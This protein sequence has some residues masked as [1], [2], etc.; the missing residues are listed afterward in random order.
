MPEI[1]EATISHLGMVQNVVSRMA[2]NSLVLKALAVTLM[3]GVL[4]FTGASQ[5][6]SPVLALAALV[7]VLA[8]WFLDAHYL[9]LERLFR[10]LYDAVRRG[11]VTESF[12]MNF[13][14]FEAGEQP[15]LRIAFSWSVGWFYG[16]LLIVLIVLFLALTT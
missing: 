5:D 14:R 4:A 9:R 6:P 13:A 3:A 7:P 10:K 16:T 15:T 2:A 12:D 8:F 11:E 1:D